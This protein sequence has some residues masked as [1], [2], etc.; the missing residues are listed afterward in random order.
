MRVRS[1]FLGG[2]KT[3]LSTVALRKQLSIKNFS[4]QKGQPHGFKGKLFADLIN[5]I[6]QLVCGFKKD[7]QG[8]R[9]NNFLAL[10]Y[11]TRSTTLGQISSLQNS[12]SHSLSLFCT[13]VVHPLQTNGSTSQLSSVGQTMSWGDMSTLYRNQGGLCCPNGTHPLET[14]PPLESPRRF[15]FCSCV[16][17]LL[18]LSI[19]IDG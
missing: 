6:N 11:A 1:G 4:C 19:T 9:E 15:R 13:R 2:K 17:I 8:K 14:P 18:F 16:M 12:S 5:T 10:N 3:K 7:H